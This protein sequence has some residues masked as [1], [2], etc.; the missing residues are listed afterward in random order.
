VSG[1]AWAYTGVVL[2]AAVS[3]A[4]NVAHSY[5][6]PEDAPPAWSPHAGAVVGAV[7]WPVALLVSLEILA[8][9]EWPS[10]WRWTAVR[11]LGLIPVGVVAAVVSYR[12]MSGLL[13]WYGEESITCDLGPLAVDGL[14]VMS[15]GA[16]LATARTARAVEAAAEDSPTEP[17][18][19]EPAETVKPQ[20]VLDLVA[21]LDRL[22]VPP[23]TGREKSRQ[24]LAK[25]GR[26]ASTGDLSEAVRLR[27]TG[28]RA[29]VNGVDRELERAGT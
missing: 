20:V 28:D 4:A 26:R 21:T 10:G 27:K 5:V 12:H 1:R 6:P 24:E 23:G 19:T 9:V 25:V 2:G 15:A 16:L 17:L 11:Y 7:F 29:K 14:M 22:G 3:V 13:E 18:A 8:R